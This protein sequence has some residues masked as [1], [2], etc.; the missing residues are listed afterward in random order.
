[1]QSDGDKLML[2][3]NS[4]YFC[5]PSKYS[6]TTTRR[7]DFPN[8]TTRYAELQAEGW[9]SFRFNPNLRLFFARNWVLLYINENENRCAERSRSSYYRF[10]F[11]CLSFGHPVQNKQILKSA[12][13][14]NSPN[15]ALR[16]DSKISRFLHAFLRYN[17]V[18]RIPNS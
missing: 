15:V 4:S 18:R 9:D 10:T 6:S 7:K 16:E 3:L 13:N 17:E 8:T 5:L 1:M 2:D 12:M 14:I 11:L